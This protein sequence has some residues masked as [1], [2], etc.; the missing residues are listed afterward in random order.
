MVIVEPAL[1]RDRKD[2][3]VGRTDMRGHLG[4][5]LD[6][7][8]NTVL[9]CLGGSAVVSIY[10]TDRVFA[11]G[12]VTNLYR[13][14]LPRFVSVS[15]DF[16]CFYCVMDNDFGNEVWF[17]IPPSY[18]EMLAATPV[19][20]PSGEQRHMLDM[21]VRQFEWMCSAGGGIH[22][23]QMV[24]NHVQNMLLSIDNELRRMTVTPQRVFP[25]K[26]YE[27]LHRFYRLVT[28]HCRE[29]H[30]VTWY[31]CRLTITPYYLSS[32]TARYTRQ[33]PKQ[34]IDDQIM[35]E[36]KTLLNTT[37]LP[38]KE[39]AAVMHFPDTSYMCRYFRRKTGM[40]FKEYKLGRK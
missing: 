39:I 20:T 11:Q 8:G 10:S 12:D 26:G 34:I 2:F 16:E 9:V 35:L 7:C 36:I 38:L 40:S 37:S 5:M 25:D 18:F 19:L 31:A 23:K 6:P 1:L 17:D 14:M 28:D 13:D 27:I 32:I 29:H 21:W 3:V 24:K 15:A 33:S 4:R 30:D 22:A